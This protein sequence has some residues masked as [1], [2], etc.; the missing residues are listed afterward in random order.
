MLNKRNEPIPSN[1][2]SLSAA[3]RKFVERRFKNL[4]SLECE[5]EKLLCSVGTHE[6]VER[7]ADKA[8][9]GE[10]EIADRP[11]SRGFCARFL[12]PPTWSSNTPVLSAVSQLT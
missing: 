11:L 12:S 10:V 8:A 9:A 1:A 5:A 2:I 6:L 3:F 4:S 7:M